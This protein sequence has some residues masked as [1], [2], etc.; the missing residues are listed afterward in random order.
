MRFNEKRFAE[1][2]DRRLIDEGYPGNLLLAVLEK[3]EG[4]GNIIDIGA[5][6]GFFTIPL[7]ERGF[8]VHAVEPS[9]KMTSLMRK[10][11]DK[12]ISPNITISNIGWEDWTGEHYDASLCIHS[13]YPMKD[14]LK[15][16]ENMVSFSQ[17]RILAVRKPD[18]ETLTGKIK[19]LF[20]KNSVTT[21][22]I[23]MTEE[24]LN[25][26]GVEFRKEDIFQER[27]TRFE[28]LE[29]GVSYY[30]Y[31]LKIEKEQ[32]DLLRE[33]LA[34]LTEESDGFHVFRSHYHDILYTF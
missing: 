33:R 12:R 2:Y 16:L 25:S 23:K 26:G 6:S 1:E 20:K 32:T 10:K 17:R 29:E 21:D 27:I 31:F 28:S 4:I 24:Y 19:S 15:G 5:G 13:L 34:E 11:I 3:L 9:E 18:S 8:H 7:A 30:R 14:P 22:Y